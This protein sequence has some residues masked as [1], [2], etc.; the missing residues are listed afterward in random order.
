MELSEWQR[1]TKVTSRALRRTLG[2]I[3]EMLA[4]YIESLPMLKQG[5]KSRTRRVTSSIN[6]IIVCGTQS[7]RVTRFT[8]IRGVLSLVRT[9]TD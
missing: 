4:Q 1:K 5:Y 8:P 9:P 3:R 2:T 7:K 6:I